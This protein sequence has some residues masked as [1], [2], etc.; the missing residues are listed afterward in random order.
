M[1]ATAILA[2]LERFEASAPA[3]RLAL[4]SSV[5]ELA[6][7]EFRPSAELVGRKQMVAIDH[8]PAG[9][10]PADP[11]DELAPYQSLGFI[12]AEDVLHECE[13]SRRIGRLLR[14][15]E[16]QSDRQRAPVEPGGVADE[17]LPLRLWRRAGE[18]LDE[19]PGTTPR[20]RLPG[21]GLKPSPP[22]G[23]VR[24][25]EARVRQRGLCP[26]IGWPTRQRLAV[27]LGS[28]GRARRV[29]EKIAHVQERRDVGGTQLLS[30]AIVGDRRI[31]SAGVTVGVGR[32]DR[33]NP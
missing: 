18:P 8:A 17:P 23:V 27:S 14:R 28:L 31:H 3:E 2:D 4:A 21:Q 26:G 12:A 33:T 22:D 25:Q 5:A 11:P 20:R 32:R 16:Q 9:P 7:P 29:E 1:T 10:L 19:V 6:G 13:E 24:L 15:V 30:P